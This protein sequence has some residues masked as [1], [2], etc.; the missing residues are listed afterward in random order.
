[1]FHSNIIIALLVAALFAPVS[2][3]IGGK[4][5]DITKRPYM[6]SLMYLEEHNLEEHICGAIIISHTLLI[7]AAHCVFERAPADISIRVGS[8]SWKDG[9][10]IVFPY[11]ITLHP[12]WQDRP[13]DPDHNPHDP[14][15]AVIKLTKPLRFTDKISPS[16]L[17]LDHSLTRPES[18]LRLT[19]CGWGYLDYQPRLEL[20]E[21]QEL[22]MDLEH[23][24]N[25][26][27]YTSWPYVSQHMICAE[28]PNKGSTSP[29][30]SGGPLVD[31]HTGMVVGV[32][33][34]GS[35][36]YPDGYTWIGHT[37]I[38][39]F[40]EEHMAIEGRIKAYGHLLEALYTFLA[41]VFPGVCIFA[42]GWL[43]L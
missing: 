12:L 36:G 17:A 11:S 21:I 3:I 39:D 31:V 26:Y 2:A 29:G 41:I 43:A 37:N 10:R 28:A 9:G 19:V 32:V 13:H 38:R 33:Y 8:N 7:T 27:R 30:D 16:I 25:A 20:H 23:C 22:A 14:D 40:I 42:F 6:A 15:I 24:R 34:M 18:G 35:E 4:P 1:M 5:V